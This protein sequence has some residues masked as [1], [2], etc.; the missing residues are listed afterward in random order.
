M[1]RIATLLR[2]DFA[3]LPQSSS[4]HDEIGYRV[5]GMN[6]KLSVSLL[7]GQRL[8]IRPRLVEAMQELGWGGE[9]LSGSRARRKRRG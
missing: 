2:L 9:A 7:L 3:P 8:A 1:L 4:S 6:V 5:H